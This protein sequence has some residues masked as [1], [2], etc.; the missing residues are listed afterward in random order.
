MGAIQSGRKHIF[1]FPIR[2]V[3]NNQKIAETKQNLKII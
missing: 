2:H 3:K 1:L